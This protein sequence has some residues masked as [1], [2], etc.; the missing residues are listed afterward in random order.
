MKINETHPGEKGLI[1]WGHCQNILDDPRKVQKNKICLFAHLHVLASSSI[2]NINLRLA[3]SI[4][5]K[6]MLHFVK[7]V[8]FSE[9]FNQAR[10]N[11]MLH[12]FAQD[13]CQLDWP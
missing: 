2:S 10:S 1:L 5:S 8:Q 4:F 12:N 11:I 6:T 7:Y 3:E 13:T 9:V